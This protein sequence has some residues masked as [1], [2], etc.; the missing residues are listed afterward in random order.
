MSRRLKSYLDDD[1]LKA[2]KVWSEFERK[3]NKYFKSPQSFK[4][5]IWNNYISS[6]GFVSQKFSRAEKAHTVKLLTKTKGYNP[7]VLIKITGADQNFNQLKSHIKYISRDGS[8]EVF[9]NDTLTGDDDISLKNIDEIAE[10]F[11]DGAHDI[12]S[13]REQEKQNLKPKNEVL[14][15][16][17]SMKGENNIPGQDIKS[18]AAKTIKE[19]FPNHHFIVAIHNDT[20]NPHCHLDLKLVDKNGKNRVKVTPQ[21]LDKMRSEFAK[22]LTELGHRAVN[23]SRKRKDLST[24]KFKDTWDGH[25]AHHYKITGYGKAKYNFSLDEHVEDSYYVKFETKN[26]KESILWGKH[27]EQLMDDYNITNGDY[28]R[29]AITNQEPVVKKIFDKKTKQWY[30]KTVYKNIWDCS[31]EGKREIELKPLS[32]SEKKKTEFKALVGSSTPVIVSDFKERA[33]SNTKQNKS[34]TSVGVAKNSQKNTLTKP[35]IQSGKDTTIK[36]QDF[37]R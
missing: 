5:K 8:L 35:V 25:K 15:M 28:A 26:G 18:A 6:K 7:Q 13:K 10:T 29:F 14:H 20:D 31:V 21:D 17:F 12:L 37:E 36:K 9:V 11:I 23:F 27:L 16:V 34:G 4:D 24:N 33:V 19:K 32:Q 2:K 3:Q 1:F 22:N 30:E